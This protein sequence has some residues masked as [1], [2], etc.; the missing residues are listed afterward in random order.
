MIRQSNLIL[1]YVSG[2]SLFASHSFEVFVRSAKTIPDTDLVVLTD[3]ISD[4]HA[5]WLEDLDVEIEDGHKAG[6]IFR[7]RH[8]AYWK[9]LNDHGYKYK[10]AMTT[11]GRDVM[12]Q[13]SPFDWALGWK[14]RFDSIRGDK[15][16]LGCFVILTAEGH[17][18]SQSGFACIEEFEF[19]RD[20]HKEL[21]K[22][23]HNRWIVNGGVAVGTPRALQD[24]HM[25]VWAMMTKTAGRCTDQA[26]INWL[27]HYLEDDDM[28][29]VS[30]PQHDNLC[31]TGEG[32]KEGAVTPTIKEGKVFNPKGVPYCLIHQ[33]DRV[34]Y[35]KE[36]VLAQYPS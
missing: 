18:M 32:V 27:F 24:H 36:T 33:W 25:T 23:D 15:K 4:G 11:D 34:E 26:A 20:T 9:Y 14:T 22:S 31:L 17:K 7:D 19:Q 16:F 30:F 28:Y 12:F 8:L 5:Q 6:Y 10:L 21:H 29:S 3:E 1:T 2:E 13:S 35:L